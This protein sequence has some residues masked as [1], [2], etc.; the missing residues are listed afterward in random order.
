[1]DKIHENQ[2]GEVLPYQFEPE[3]L[4]KTCD[5]SDDSNSEQSGIMSSFD[6]DV[7]QEFEREN[8]CHLRDLSWCKCG[9][10]SLYT[11]V[12]ECFCC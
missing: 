7:D 8:A 1:M 10:C 2:M 11:K 5:S 6:E 3:L 9:H 4:A 12:V